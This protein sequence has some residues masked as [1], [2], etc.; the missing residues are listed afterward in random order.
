MEKAVKFEIQIDRVI[1]DRA[2]L[3][4]G[5]S[6][7]D[8]DTLSPLISES[9]N[10]AL[11]HCADLLRPAGLT[12]EIKASDFERIFKG[13]GMNDPQAPLDLIFRKASSLHLFSVTVGSSVSNHV[14]SLFSSGDYTTGFFLD[15]AASFAVDNMTTMLESKFSSDS[16]AAALSYSPGYC[17]WDLSGQKRLFTALQPEQ[18]EVFLLDSLLMNPIKSSSGVIVCGEPSIHYFVNN[19]T[20][21]RSCKH[22]TCR[23]RIRSLGSV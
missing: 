18:I 3:L 10:M 21:C 7:P 20:F 12:L 22:R 6:M 1:P 17:G 8:D 2:A 11:V 13:E 16:K 4:S 14:R 15:A 19:F 5:Q 23:E 9:V